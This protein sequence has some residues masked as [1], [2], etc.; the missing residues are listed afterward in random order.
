MVCLGSHQGER[1]PVARL[2]VFTDCERDVIVR[3]L[4]GPRHGSVLP[5]QKELD[6]L[7]YLLVQ[8][9]HDA[10]APLLKRWYGSYCFLCL[11]S[12]RDR[13]DF[14]RILRARLDE[15]AGKLEVFVTGVLA[16][17][18]PI[19]EVAESPLQSLLLSDTSDF[20]F[21]LYA[22]LLVNHLA[23]HVSWPFYP[24]LGSRT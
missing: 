10:T 20:C 18:D 15:I 3:A 12:N 23:P 6:T 17:V 24:G 14:A 16:F 5:T 9:F 11:A 8:A 21:R 13:E 4:A 19:R 1:A 22:A 7:D 2:R